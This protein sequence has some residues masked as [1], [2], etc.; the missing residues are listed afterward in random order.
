MCQERDDL[1]SVNGIRIDLP[2]PPQPGIN[3]VRCFSDTWPRLRHHR[4]AEAVHVSAPGSRSKSSILI[5]EPVISAPDKLVKF[6]VHYAAGSLAKNRQLQMRTSR[7]SSR[8]CLSRR[9]NGTA[10]AP[11]VHVAEEAA[12]ALLELRSHERANMFGRTWNQPPLL[13]GLAQD[14]R[15]RYQYSLSRS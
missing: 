8:C 1:Q 14:A 6:V 12:L 13:L 5:I 7:P 9:K 11:I 3:G 2:S 4:R 15:S 10:V